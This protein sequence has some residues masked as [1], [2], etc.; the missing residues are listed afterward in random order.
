MGAMQFLKVPGNTRKEKRR[1]LSVLTGDGMVT[2]I[3]E[4]GGFV[5]KP[6]KNDVVLL[7]SG[8]VMMSASNT[9]VYAR[10]VVS[11]DQED[12]RRVSSMLESLI[13]EFT[14]IRNP[15]SGRPA[16]VDYLRHSMWVCLLLVS[17]CGRGRCFRVQKLPCACADCQVCTP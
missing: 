6:Q 13:T 3:R 15:A 14:E 16:F 5:M 8:F 12:A 1:N 2:L 11:G 9:C 17:C 7:P 4:T 10:W